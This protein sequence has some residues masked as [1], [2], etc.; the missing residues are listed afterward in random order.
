MPINFKKRGF[1]K[2]IAL[3]LR[4]KLI[5]PMLRSKA[6]PEIT[7][8]GSLVG[9]AWAMT[10]LVGIQMYLVFMTW[11]FTRKVF[12]WDF[13]LP[14][15]LA[16]TWVTNVFTVPPF[17]YAFYVTGK[18]MT[19]TFAER[20]T[21]AKFYDLIKTILNENGIVEALKATAAVLIKDWGFSMMIG[22]LP[23]IVFG[24]WGAYAWTLWYIRRR[25][26]TLEKRLAGKQKKLEKKIETTQKNFERKIEKVGRK[27]EISQQR[28]ENRQ[29]KLEDK[30]EQT[31]AAR[32]EAQETSTEQNTDDV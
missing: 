28:F 12:K 4:V 1:F 20:T 3:L 15:G 8:R 22:S 7:A 21:Y 11:L 14:V 27:L 6:A 18:I 9:M 32:Q 29:K 19:G 10:P 25:R 5:V 31:I 30:L 16:W 26:K 17:Y 13:S 23:W 24:G 2:T